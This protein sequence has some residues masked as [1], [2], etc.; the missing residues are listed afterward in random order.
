MPTILKTLALVALGA[1]LTSAASPPAD[2]R[3]IAAPDRALPD[4]PVLPRPAVLVVSKTS[5]YRHESIAKAV[6]AIER[7]A[8]ARNWGVF[9]TEDAAVFNPA[10]LKKFDVVVFA[11]ATGDFYTPQQRAAFEAWIA[12][13]GG[14]VGLHSAG[15][16]SHP[17]WFVRMRG[18]GNFTGHPGGPDQIQ[19]S[20]LIVTDRS[21]PATRHLPA[22]WRWADEFYSCDAPPRSD[23]RVLVRLDEAGMRLEPALRMGRDHALV[24]WRCEGRG[25]IFYSALGHEPKAWTDPTHL[26][27]VDGAIGW[28]A[29][30]RADG[31]DKRS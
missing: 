23:A 25:R 11:N 17:A 15:D 8:K 24:W 27:L 29:R 9:A 2:S 31:C 6:A 18:N 28:A 3:A 16:Q 7:I 12:T 1:S 22:R 5:G 4:L 13:G 14:F 26:K 21:H 30:A 10:Q 19:T 20:E